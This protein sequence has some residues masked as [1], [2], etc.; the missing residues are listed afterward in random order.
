MRT[1]LGSWI[2]PLLLG[3]CGTELPAVNLF[4]I[5][6]DI[7]LGAQLRDEINANPK[8][9]GNVLDPAD[10]ANAEAY[11]HLQRITDEILSSDEVAH[12]DEF[13]WELYIIDDPETLNAFCAPGGYIY[14]YTGIV[15]YL[16]E[17]DHFAGVMGHEIA[18]AAQRH[19]TQQLSKAYGVSVLLGVIFGSDPGLIAQVAAGL[20]S[21]EF[22][23]TD[24]S[25]A[26]EYSVYYLCDTDYAANGTAGFFQ[27]IVDEGDQ[28]FVPEFLSTH[29]S[30]DN[31]VENINILAEDLGCSLELNPN[32]D[33]AGFQSSLP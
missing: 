27:K 1:L 30:P 19:S 4:T 28:G 29:P 21:L 17:E 10:P 9:Y 7:E 23:R 2:A 12:R 26:D 24:E 8:E 22:S 25:E 16:D 32:A 3:A 15:K 13:P 11:A 5:E 18:H 14:V 33:W 6:D 20:L 31:R